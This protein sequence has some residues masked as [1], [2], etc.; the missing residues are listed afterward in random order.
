M[1]AVQSAA[2]SAIDIALWDILAKSVNLPVS[3]LLGGKCHD[4]VKVFANV[5]GATVQRVCAKRSQRR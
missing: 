2:I 1:G 3:K 4:K 5:G